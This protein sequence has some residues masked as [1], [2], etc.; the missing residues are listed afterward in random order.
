MLRIAK[1]EG[2]SDGKSVS[3]VL[4][5][6]LSPLHFPSF[7]PAV[8]FLTAS[9]P[10]PIGLQQALLK[11]IPSSSIWPVATMTTGLCALQNRVAPAASNLGSPI[12]SLVAQIKTRRSAIVAGI[13]G[14]QIITAF[15][16]PGSDCCSIW[17]NTRLVLRA[18]SLFHSA[19]MT[20]FRGLVNWQ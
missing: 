10:C 20:A 12:T 5:S 11:I 1:D 16:L 6:A 7:L 15:F 13:H 4:R 18:S 17:H 14:Y 2:S 19:I 3:G 9:F 8:P